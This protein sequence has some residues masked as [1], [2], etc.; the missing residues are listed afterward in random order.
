[1]QDQEGPGDDVVKE[2]AERQKSDTSRDTSARTAMVEANT[3]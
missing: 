2:G 1:M 3:C